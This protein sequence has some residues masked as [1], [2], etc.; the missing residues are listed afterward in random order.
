MWLLVLAVLGMVA[1]GDA[2][3]RE[4]TSEPSLDLPVL[5]IGVDGLEWDVLLPLLHQG[6][7]PA[8]ARLMKS[9]VYG[10]LETFSPTL[11]PVIW[12]SVATG[13]VPR[14][15]GI[16]HMITPSGPAGSLRLYDSRDRRTK[17]LWN[18]FS[19]AGRTVHVIGWWLTFPTEKVRGSMV[20]Q[21]NTELQV[22]TVAAARRALGVW[23]G[24]LVRGQAGQV[25]PS[26]LQHRVM[27]IVDEVVAEL[28]RSQ[29]EIFGEAPSPRSPL[30]S[31]LVENSLWALRADQI[32][33]SV[34]TKLLA[35]GDEFDLLMLYFGG[36]DV[37]SHRFW[38]YLHPEQFKHPPSAREIQEFSGVIPRYYERVDLFLG[39]LMAHLAR[40]ANVFV[41]SDHGMQ[42]T[43]RAQVFRP[44]LPAEAANSGGHDDPLPG[45]LIAAGKQL[46]RSSGELPR[47]AS[48]LPVLGNV[49]DLAPTILLLK[50][51]PIGRDMDGRVLAEVLVDGFLEAHSP[52]YID[53]HDTAAWRKA[54]AIEPM[55]P[56]ILTDRERALAQ[57]ADSWMALNNVAWTLATC[58]DAS[59]RDG[60]RAVVL[61]ERASRI[62]Q[63]GDSEFLD[64]LA[65]AYAEA[66]RFPEAVTTI[67]QAAQIAADAGQREGIV[68]FEQRR[69]LYQAGRPLRVAGSCPRRGLPAAAERERIEQLRALGYLD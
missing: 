56:D 59:I 33:F 54:R 68:R 42:A 5:L 38:R 36:T 1:C 57:A 10:R 20:A 61:A 49:L 39:K 25:H 16:L 35:P 27:E 37:V 28:P 22:D 63:D 45:V 52:T 8:L 2:S 48:A 34:A 9:G 19:D 67:T 65:A 6:R 46:R 15:H 53:T 41:V 29:A 17:A 13:K 18:I 44:D 32:Y 4:Q 30:E 60:E 43:N 14:K 47:T 66:G 62:M 26:R 51:L 7:L 21:T 55:Q 50:G 23:K 31:E 3:Q 58:P 24:G 12:T 11:S 40:D 69:E 64:T